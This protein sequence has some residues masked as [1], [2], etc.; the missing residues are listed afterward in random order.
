M[1]YLMDNVDD[2]GFLNKWGTP[3]AVWFIRGN[4]IYKWMIWGYP[5]LRNPPY[6]SPQFQVVYRKTWE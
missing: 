2:L 6:I 3:I 5:N 4:P 1:N